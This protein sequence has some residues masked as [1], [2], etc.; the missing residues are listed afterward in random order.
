MDR[1]FLTQEIYE[2][3]NKL[4]Q[5]MREHEIDGALIIQKVDLYY[6]TGTDQDAHLWIPASDQPILMVRKSLERALSDSLIEKIIPL[7]SLSQLPVY[8]NDHGGKGSGRL[9]L[10]MDVVPVK[11]YL[12]YQRLFPHKTMVD[13]SPLIRQLRMIKSPYEISLIKKASQMADRLYERI[14]E[15]LH[16]SETEIEL[17]SKAEAFYRKGGH[18]GIT[19]TRTF[20]M[21]SVYGHIMGGPNST[22]P[23]NSPGPTAGSGLGPYLSQGSGF[24]RIGTHEPIIVDYASNVGG[25][26]SDQARI[27]SKGEL[28]TKFY[29]AHDVML[30]VQETLAREGRPGAKARDL[31]VLAL[32][33]VKDAGFLEGFMGYPLAVPFVAHGIG[34]EMDE[35]PLIAKDSDHILQEGM[36][37]AM[38]PKFVFP[39]EGVVGIENTFAVTE[40]GLERLNQYPDEIVIC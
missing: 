23:S 1:P 37:F 5:L 14:P 25:Y 22:I 15:F 16:E 7:Q 24:H 18:P 33:V 10:E 29:R 39:N 11:M 8:I 26:I 19:R 20:N 4:Q 2:R 30:K 21:E 12:G 6:L 13:I 27:F 31:Y 34:L 35:W 3:I 40:G 9:G 28:D 32:E 17:A 36:I 38:E